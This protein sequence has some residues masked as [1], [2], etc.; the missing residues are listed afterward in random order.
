[1]FVRKV[2]KGNFKEELLF[3]KFLK[4]NNRA[5]DVLKA[6]NGFFEKNSLDWGNLVG[7]TT[8]SAAT[9]L[10][11]QSGFQTLVKQRAPLAIGVHCF[12]Y[13]EALASKALP[14]QLN[15]TFKTL[16]KVVNYVKS[17]ALNTRLLQKIC[18]NMDSAF[19]VL[20]FHTAV[21]WLSARSILNRIFIRNKELIEFLQ[22]KGKYDFKNFLAESEWKLAYL[23][24]I[25]SILNRLNVQL[26]E[27]G[28]NLFTHQGII[29]AFVEK[30]QLCINRVENSNFVQFPYLNVTVG[31]KRDIQVHVLEHLSKLKD[32]FTQLF[33]EVDMTRDDLFFIRDPFA[34]D[35]HTVPM[36]FQE[37]MLELKNDLSVKDLY[38]QFTLEK[39]WSGMLTAYPEVSSYAITQLLSFTSTYLCECGFS[40]LLN[41]KSNREIV[42]KQ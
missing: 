10:G 6:V 3:C 39:F 40:S 34:A 28:A 8:D 32:E 37:Q 42:L 12:I 14:N 17:S 1:M 9:M 21:R 27:K 15:T 38:K 7:I 2:H 22:S 25:V 19:E 23:V 31:D 5:E 24:D 30:L 33:P 20:L 29:K 11:S 41:M 4:L 18:H 36:D 16:V 26:Q 13:R 35:I